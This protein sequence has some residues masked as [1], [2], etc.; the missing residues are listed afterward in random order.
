MRIFTIGHSNYPIDYFISLLK[1]NKINCV[2]DVRSTPYSK[3]TPQ[4]NREEV[5]K[6]LNIKGITYIHM[7]EEF[8]ARREKKELYSKEGYLDFEKT[9]KDSIFLSGVDRIINGC[10]KGY[11]IALMCTE[12]DPFDCH[13]C[14][15]VGKG[16]EDNGFEVDHIMQGNK[17][18]KQK[19]IERKLL[20]KYFKDRNQIMLE[21][22][23]G[24]ILSIEEMIEESYKKR[25][26]EIGYHMDEGE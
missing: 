10:K 15:M 22:V 9:R 12:K 7:G 23:Q 26:K 13:R 24:K 18:I 3:Y 16:L 19:E 11:N 8:G 20:D 1:I 25:N 21:S 6:L 2:V 17:H 4:Y 14:I 5:K